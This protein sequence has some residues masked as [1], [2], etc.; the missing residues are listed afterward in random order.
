MAHHA[1]PCAWE[2]AATDAT[3]NT[4]MALATYAAV[5]VHAYW[6][7]IAFLSVFSEREVYLTALRTGYTVD[8]IIWRVLHTLVRCS[9]GPAAACVARPAAVLFLISW[10]LT[11]EVY[12][13][14][15]FVGV[16]GFHC[17]FYTGGL[18]GVGSKTL[19]ATFGVG[20]PI[21]MSVAV[22]V[23]AE[24]GL[25]GGG[26]YGGT[27]AA[28]VAVGAWRGAAVAALISMRLL[29]L[30]AAVDALPPWAASW[31]AARD[32]II[33]SSPWAERT[34]GAAL[35][36]EATGQE[37]TPAAEKKTTARGCARGACPTCQAK[38]ARPGATSDSP[39][40]SP[41]WDLEPPP[42]PPVSACHRELI[43]GPP[44]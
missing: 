27:W 38:A 18:R 22:L 4:L 2:W 39:P 42:K 28:G 12:L 1:H 15:V 23:A 10:D 17:W 29:S 20:F 43:I 31:F 11:F 26:V 19:V 16:M 37:R 32:T 9:V 40:P 35:L 33:V 24:G 36:D 30:R 41:P 44:I 3:S 21:A 34:Y 8:T 7:G 14:G 25:G 5:T 6:I 13:C